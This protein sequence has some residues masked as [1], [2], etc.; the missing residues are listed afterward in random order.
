MPISWPWWWKPKAS[1]LHR[2]CKIFLLIWLGAVISNLPAMGQDVDYVRSLIEDLTG[3]EFHGRGYVRKGDLRAARYI[4]KVFHAAGLSSPFPDMFQTFPVTVNT[5][6]GKLSLSL[7]DEKLVPGADY[8][9]HPGSPSHRGKHPVLWLDP[10]DL[11]NDSLYKYLCKGQEGK[12]I[13][14]STKDLQEPDPL[15]H[16]LIHSPEIPIEGLILT[17]GKKLT[18][19][20]AKDRIPR[21]VIYVMDSILEAPPG[22]IS[23]KLQSEFLEAYTTRNVFAWIRGSKQPDSLILFTAHYDHLGRMGRET[24]FPGANDNASGIAL[25]LDFVRHYAQPENQPDY[26]LGFLATSAE[27]LGLVG[28][29]YFVQNPPLPLQKIRFLLNIDLAGTGSGGITV[30]NGKVFTAEYNIL[31]SLNRAHDYLP[32]IKARG[33]A[34]NSDHCPFYRK[35]VPSFFTYTRGGPPHYH[36]IRDRSQTLPLTGYEPYFKLL[37]DF[38]NSLQNP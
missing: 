27:E 33:E 13:G 23:L 28:S 37:R 24:L 26:T 36:D 18:W 7:D 22:E 34:C 14:L 38:I 17:R 29:L 30:V 2:F 6:P 8:L 5:F 1:D 16:P 19:W 31:D 4:R 35:G 21:P 15:I 32:E 9:V 20:A 12:F 10:E 25:M 3:P 11:K